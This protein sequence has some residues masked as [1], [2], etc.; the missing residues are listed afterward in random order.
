MIIHQT[1]PQFKRLSLARGRECASYPVDSHLCR[2]AEASRSAKPLRLRLVRSAT[3]AARGGVFEAQSLEIVCKGIR[4]S[5]SLGRAALQRD[6]AGYV[7]ARGASRLPDCHLEDMVRAHLGPHPCIA[8]SPARKCFNA[9][10]ALT[11]AP[12]HQHG[13][14]SI[15]ARL[16]GNFNARWQPSNLPNLRRLFVEARSESEESAYSRKAVRSL[17]HCQSW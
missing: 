1:C 2:T 9:P 4:N 16:H 15:A 12:K 10:A 5:A 11:V 13:K 6:Y 7:N 17:Q 14:L 8:S 3:C